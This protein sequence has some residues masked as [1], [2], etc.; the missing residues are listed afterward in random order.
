M[1]KD[2]IFSHMGKRLEFL[3]LIPE[4]LIYHQE[5]TSY[6]DIDEDTG[7]KLYSY[8]DSL[9]INP[10]FAGFLAR[11]SPIKLI[12]LIENLF[13][14][15]KLKPEFKNTIFNYNIELINT[16]HILDELFI[17]ELSQYNYIIYSFTNDPPI[18]TKYLKYEDKYIKYKEKYFRLKNNII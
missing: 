4:K 1:D 16:C 14:F 15:F 9:L 18:E 2:E 10:D 6:F 8:C 7:L 17:D 5:I 11:I 12:I 13:K 3:T